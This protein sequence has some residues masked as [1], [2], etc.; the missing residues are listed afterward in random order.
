M[1]RTT[2]NSEPAFIILV[3]LFAILLTSAAGA[4]MIAPLLRTGGSYRLLKEWGEERK[5]QR[6][7]LLQLVRGAESLDTVIQTFT[8]RS[9][10]LQTIASGGSSIL[11]SNRND[12]K[13]SHPVWTKRL[14][15]GREISCDTGQRESGWQRARGSSGRTCK[16]DSLDIRGKLIVRGSVL[17]SR[18]EVSSGDQL[19]VLGDLESESVLLGS[20]DDQVEIFATGRI[21][22]GGL[23]ALTPGAP[24]RIVSGS[25]PLEIR[26][27]V[28]PDCSVSGLK[29]ELEARDGIKIGAESVASPFGC[30]EREP[31]KVLSIRGEDLMAV[32]N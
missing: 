6:E 25:G 15:A 10:K 7:N 5:A 24:V 1:N 14:S 19:I 21:R 16:F 11:L 28:V 4:A 32:G 31:L 8:P 3:V 29:I 18:L 9:P 20:F 17:A 30:S 27:R 13:L 12:Q 23:Q 22:I 26:Q 2:K